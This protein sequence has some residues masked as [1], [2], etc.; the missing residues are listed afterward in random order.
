MYGLGK[1]TDADFFVTCIHLGSS[2]A[3][4]LLLIFGSFSKC[5]LRRCFGA[6]DVESRNDGKEVF[7]TISSRVAVCPVFL[8]R[9]L[10]WL[11]HLVRYL[12]LPP[13]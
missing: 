10:M 9:R 13:S 11:L 7:S 1:T 6:A 5:P 8:V 12:L 3:A 4:S 2:T